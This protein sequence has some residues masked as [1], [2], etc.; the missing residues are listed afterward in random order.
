MRNLFTA[1]LLVVGVLLC[2][3][4][5]QEANAAIRLGG[6]SRGDRKP[7]TAPS[8]SNPYGAGSR[9]KSNGY[10]RSQGRYSYSTRGNHYLNRAPRIYDYKGRYRGNLSSNRHDP[11]SIYNPIGRFGNPY[12]L[13]SVHNPYIIGNQY[14]NLPSYRRYGR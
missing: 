2:S 8:S 5:A 11:D 12:S 14:L 9:Y 1:M 10:N 6:S 3:L 4:M 7:S 13:D